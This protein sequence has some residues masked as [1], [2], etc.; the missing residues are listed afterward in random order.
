MPWNKKF[1]IDGLLCDQ[2]KAFDC[3]NHDVLI[4]KLKHCGI[5]ESTLNCFTSY[6]SKRRERTKSSFNK[7]QIYYTTWEIVKQGV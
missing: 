3:V 2:T 5:Q 6:P 7:D 1:H 4:A